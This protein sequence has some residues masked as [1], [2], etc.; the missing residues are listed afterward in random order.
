MMPDKMQDVH[1]PS[2]STSDMRLH[3]SLVTYRAPTHKT[4]GKTPVNLFGVQEAAMAA[5]QPA[6]SGSPTKQRAIHD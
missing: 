3:L 2:A 5:L 4:T 1:E 6:V